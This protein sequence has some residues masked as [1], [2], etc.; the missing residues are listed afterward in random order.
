MA[1][2][3]VDR[4]TKRF[5]DVTAI[6][7]VSLTIPSGEFVVLLG[8]TGAGKSTLLRL[9]AGLETADADDASVRRFEA[10]NQTQQ[11]ALASAGRSEQYHEFAARNG[12]A[13]IVDRRNVAEALGNSVYNNFSH[14]LP[15]Q[16]DV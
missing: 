3:I 2:I 6:D 7:D 12:K 5:G 16:D 8:P 14:D 13:D 15:L 11:C 4:V 1:E 10:G 9:I